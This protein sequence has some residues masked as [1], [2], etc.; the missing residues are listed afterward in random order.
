[1]LVTEDHPLHAPGRLG[2]GGRECQ[3]ADRDVRIG[4]LGV[5]VGVMP[6]VL[7][8]PPV[9]ADPGAEVAARDA[10][11]GVG[12]PGTE[13]LAVRGIV[14]KEAKLGEDDRQEHRVRQLPP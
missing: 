2:A 14:A 11:D 12:L 10:Q 8:G 9:V 7:A 5:R 6:V 13:D 1:M 4:A 3:R